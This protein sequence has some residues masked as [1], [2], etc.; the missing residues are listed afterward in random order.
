VSQSTST[1]PALRRPAR[2]A[3]ALVLGVA[4]AILTACGGGNSGTNPATTTTASATSSSAGATGSAS[5]GSGA[6]AAQSLTATEVDFKI[7]LDK[8]T[9][10]AGAY[11]IKVVNN[12]NTTHSLVVEQN[13]KDLVT[14]NPIDPGQSTTVSVTLAPGQAVIYCPIDGH[15]AMGME[16]TVPVQ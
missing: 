6:A 7:S 15:R 9:L 5:G 1:P 10:P 16:L 14:A 3:A 2:G 12:G 11:T 13:D 4:A 8:T